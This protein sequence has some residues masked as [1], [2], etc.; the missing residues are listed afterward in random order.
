MIHLN[1]VSQMPHG[2]SFN[3]HCQ[4]ERRMKVELAFSCSLPLKCVHYR[5]DLFPVSFSVLVCVPHEPWDVLQTPPKCLLTCTSKSTNSSIRSQTKQIFNKKCV[6]QAE[7]T[8]N[9]RHI[10]SAENEVDF[11]VV[12]L[13]IFLINVT[14]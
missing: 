6:I 11:D 13:F 10:L 4:K 12:G 8:N 9:S 2:F 3:K 7:S 5:T 1:K 14:L